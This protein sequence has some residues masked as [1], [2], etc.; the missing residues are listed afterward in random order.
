MKNERTKAVLLGVKFSADDDE[1]RTSKEE[2]LLGVK[3]SAASPKI[4]RR[5][6]I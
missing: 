2:V 5:K 1:E 3:F 4:V 6:R